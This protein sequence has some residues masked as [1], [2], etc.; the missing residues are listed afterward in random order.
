MWGNV[1]KCGYDRRLAA[2][3]IVWWCDVM[4]GTTGRVM[5]WPQARRAYGLQRGDGQ[6]YKRVEREVKRQIDGAGG[7]LARWV[8]VMT[9][10]GMAASG[11]VRR[12]ERREEEVQWERAT[13]K[14][15]A[16]HY[17]AGALRLL[18]LSDLTAWA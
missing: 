15:R 13:H 6:A 11:R 2:A 14:R 12:G 5:P 16:P 1:G 3:G 7:E 4:D 9:D 8:Q 18:V 17:A 10:G